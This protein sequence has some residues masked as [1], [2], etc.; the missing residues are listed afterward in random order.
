MACESQK[1][2]LQRHWNLEFGLRSCPK[3]RLALLYFSSIIWSASPSST[4]QSASSSTFISS[5]L[6][7]LSDIFNSSCAENGLH[8]SSACYTLREISS[9][10][11]LPLPELFVAGELCLELTLSLS[12]TSWYKFWFLISNELGLFACSPEIKLHLSL[13]ESTDPLGSE[14]WSSCRMEGLF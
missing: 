10:V 8:S 7:W 5:C 6:A 1:L 3:P 12:I 9:L 4:S 2:I 11:C 14:I 13:K